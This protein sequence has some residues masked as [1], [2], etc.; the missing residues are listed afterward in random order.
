MGEKSK[1]KNKQFIKQYS[2]VDCQKECTHFTSLPSNYLTSSYLRH[3]DFIFLSK[4]DILHAYENF[5]LFNFVHSLYLTMA[6]YVYKTDYRCKEI[7]GERI[8]IIF[9]KSIV[10]FLLQLNILSLLEGSIKICVR[11]FMGRGHLSMD[12][13]K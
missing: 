5:V 8:I 6:S 11:F 3:T 7:L 1:G 12:Y 10:Y 2:H 9:L 13:S 4:T